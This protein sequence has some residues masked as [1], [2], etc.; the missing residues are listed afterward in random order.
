MRE[1]GRQMGLEHIFAAGASGPHD[2]ASVVGPG[3]PTLESTVRA[4]F[5]AVYC[6]G[7]VVGVR[8]VLLKYKDFD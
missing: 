1:M 6:D 5:G 7:G 4:I 3:W 8:M 2:D